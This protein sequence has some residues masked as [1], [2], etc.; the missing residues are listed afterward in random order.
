MGGNSGRLILSTD[1]ETA[2]TVSRRLAA[3][4]ARLPGQRLA[5]RGA[6]RRPLPRCPAMLV[7]L[8]ALGLWAEAAGAAAPASAA[9]ATTP[10]DMAAPSAVG[11]TSTDQASEEASA[12]FR[13][14]LQL[15]DEGDYTLALVEFERAYQ[16][17]PNYRALYNIGLV[18]VQLGRYADASRRFEQYMR[19]GGHG[20]SDARKAEVSNT[21]AELKLRTATVAITINAPNAEVTLDGKPLEG[22]KLH[23]Q[24]LIDAGEHTLRAT[25]PGFQPGYRTITLAGSDRI[26]VRLQLV[27]IAVQRDAP[28]ERGRSVFWPG[29]LVTG[30]LAAGAVASGIV[31]LDARSRLSQLDDTFGSSSSQRANEANQV[32]SAALAA[33]ILSGLAVATGSVSLYLS[34][35]LDHAPRA[36][37]AALSPQQVILSGTF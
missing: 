4:L 7:V 20:I 14:G 1:S 2:E 29:V 22:A 28:V 11:A 5:R 34:L 12:R 15:F 24:M 30:A 25:A 19:D 37:S 10:P 36:S 27:A 13:R 26:S 6:A 31:M 23:G 32:N 21:L 3:P 16:L 8:L 35:R 17:A 18:D 9:P 33:D